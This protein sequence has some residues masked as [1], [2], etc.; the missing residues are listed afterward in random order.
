MTS[1]APIT[2][3]VVGLLEKAGKEI[4]IVLPKVMQA[5]RWP[6]ATPCHRLSQQ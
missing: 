3:T 1:R 2:R 5:V 4:P 6:K